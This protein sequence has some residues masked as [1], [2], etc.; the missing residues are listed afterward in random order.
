VLHRVSSVLSRLHRA[1]VCVITGDT[2]RHQV[3]SNAGWFVFQ[4][5]TGMGA[6]RIFSRGGQWGGL[7]DGG[8]QRGTGAE[9]APRS[10]QHVLKIMHKCFIY[11]DFRQPLQHI[12]QLPNLCMGI[13]RICMW[14]RS[15]SRCYRPWNS[16]KIRCSLS[17]F[18]VKNAK[19]VQPW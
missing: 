17:L 1:C 8:L 2:T 12:S 10:W 7:K 5:R 19:I 6:R 18:S 16:R 9:Q 3:A 13:P 4:Y 14:V 15:V 11:W